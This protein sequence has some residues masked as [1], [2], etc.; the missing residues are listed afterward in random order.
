[1]VARR[2]V[3]AVTVRSGVVP[4]ARRVTGV[5]AGPLSELVSRT[6]VKN[7]TEVKHQ[8]SSC[9]YLLR[10]TL[11]RAITKQYTSRRPMPLPIRA[12]HLQRSN[13]I[14][15]TQQCRRQARFETQTITQSFHRAHHRA[16]VWLSMLHGNAIVQI[17]IRA[18]YPQQNVV[19]VQ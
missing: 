16:I 1:V 18:D 19:R 15:R 2:A 6:A 9:A 8:A 7:K 17:F 14:H 12:L 11:E 10:V 4:C 3:R 5:C 13:Y